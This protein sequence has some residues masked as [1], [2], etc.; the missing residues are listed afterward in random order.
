MKK[1]SPLSSE[2][3]ECYVLTATILLDE[4]GVAPG[5]CCTCRCSVVEEIELFVLALEE[6]SQ[7]LPSVD[8]MVSET[9]KVY[10]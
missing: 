8:F 1:L 5:D 2:L 6:E 7:R 4:G 9:E 10:L 3:A